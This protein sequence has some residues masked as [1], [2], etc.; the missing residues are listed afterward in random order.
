LTSH[1]HLYPPVDDERE[2]RRCYLIADRNYTE[3]SDYYR[4]R[5]GVAKADR[6]DVLAT[7]SGLT[8][9]LFQGVPYLLYDGEHRILAGESVRLDIDVYGLPPNIVGTSVVLFTGARSRDP[10]QRVQDDEVRA[11]VDGVAEWVR[12]IRGDEDVTTIVLPQIPYSTNTKA[13][14]HDYVVNDYSLLSAT[15]VDGQ[16]SVTARGTTQRPLIAYVTAH[17]TFEVVAAPDTL[18]L[19]IGDGSTD[20]PIHS[21][22]GQSAGEY[23]S[24]ACTR[25]DQVNT[26][27]L[28][29]VRYRQSLGTPLVK[30]E[31]ISI[32]TL[33]A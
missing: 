6:F 7:F 31:S 10:G 14:E 18:E 30:R 3:T 4:I 17:V 5:L 26:N 1:I 12:S 16:A 25:V 28:Y 11:A 24:V 8:D 9:Q 2:I 32:L 29:K 20:A 33:E 15:F 13:Y 27:T 21:Q 19:A 23:M 22:T